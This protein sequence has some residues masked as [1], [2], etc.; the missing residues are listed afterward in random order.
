MGEIICHLGEKANSVFN[1]IPAETQY[2]R[3]NLAED[4]VGLSALPASLYPFGPQPRDNNGM[5][6]GKLPIMKTW[7]DNNDLVNLMS[8]SDVLFCKVTLGFYYVG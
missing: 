1:P 8:D 4:A 2:V 7:N 3:R 5:T 6:G